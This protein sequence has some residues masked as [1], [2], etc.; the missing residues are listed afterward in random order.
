MKTEE[1][2]VAITQALSQ[3]KLNV[4]STT[5]VECMKVIFDRIAFMFLVA[6]LILAIAA[7]IILKGKVKIDIKE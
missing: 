2:V 1:V 3:A 7:V 5:L 6:V 4:E